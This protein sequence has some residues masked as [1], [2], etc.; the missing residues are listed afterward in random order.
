VID[1]R[2]RRASRLT[3]G[4]LGGLLALLAVGASDGTYT[5]TLPVLVVLGAATIMVGSRLLKWRNLFVLL[6]VVILFIP[7]RRYTLSGSVGFQLEPYRLVVLVIV[8]LWLVALL[9]DHKV[10]LRRTGFEGP[11]MAIVG[12]TVASI[13]VNTGRI[14]ELGVQGIVTKKLTFFLS[15]IVIVYF[16]A[17]V[18]GNRTE[19][20][21]IIKVLVGGGA[22]LAFFALVEFNTG[23]DVFDHIERV[24]PLLQIQDTS[25]HSLEVRGG[26]TRVAGSGQHPIAYGSALLMLVPLAIYLARR[27]RTKAWWTAAVLLTL[28]SLATVSR[29]SILMIIVMLFLYVRIFPAYTKRLWPLLVPMLL[30]IHIALPGSL[31]TVKE[32][33]FPKGGLVKEQQGAK[34]TR[35]SGRVADLGPGLVEASRTP[36]L[37][38]GYGSRVI[39]I[40][41]LQNAPILDDQWLQTL[42]ETGILG[43]GAWLWLFISFSRRMLRRAR[44]DIDSP[45]AWLYAAL[46][47]SIASFAFG[48]LFYDAFSFI[49]VTFFAFILIALGAMLLQQERGAVAP[50]C[51]SG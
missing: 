44:E 5:P 18:I 1:A 34:G 4:A 49:Q 22:V 36:L 3:L 31:G 42:L 48:I 21:F 29:T 51:R 32:S 20:D 46:G 16:I 41:P 47:S 28:G 38:Q 27:T 9:I 30:V 13:V 2:A 23:F 12:V 33:F 37:G 43:L 19:V 7:I 50:L 25:F 14:H 39:D 17:S 11:L 45:D 10:R 6:L 15:F 35:G 24:F 26:R 8:L 40:G